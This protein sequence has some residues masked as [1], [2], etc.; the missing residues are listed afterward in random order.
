MAIQPRSSRE[1]HNDDLNLLQQLIEAPPAPRV[2]RPAPVALRSVEKHRTDALRGFLRRTWV[3]H[4]LKHAELVLVF[5]A[6]VVFGMW[7]A[8]GPLRDWL[9]A[10]EAEASKSRVAVTPTQGPTAVPLPGRVAGLLPYTTP[11]MAD[12]P[13]EPFLSPRQSKSYAPVVDVREPSRL[14][15]PKISLDTP[16]K[17]VFVVDGAWQVAEYAAGYMHGTA[18][19]GDSG[20]TALAGHAGIRG[21]VFRDLGQLAPGDELYLDAGGWRFHY[22]VRESKSVWPNQVEVLDS[23]GKAELTLMTCTNWDT[24]RLV[25][26][27]DFLDSRPSPDK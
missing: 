13:D 16:V 5:A 18:L 21:S 26:V 3:D 2:S 7:F 8:D 10:R 22:R 6:L 23:H 20:N 17:E 9:H 19:P 25:V 14:I 11:N 27:A 24:Q 12:T 4:V 15:I 1:Q